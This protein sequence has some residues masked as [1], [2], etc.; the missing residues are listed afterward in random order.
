MSGAGATTTDARL[1]ELV[2]HLTGCGPNTARGAVDEALAATPAPETVDDR[3]GVVARALVSV[4]HTQV[5]L[6]ARRPA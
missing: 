4:R 1:A 5:D 6:A 3:L 2:A